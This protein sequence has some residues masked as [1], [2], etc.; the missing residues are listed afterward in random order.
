M[1]L[2]KNV[3]PRDYT[4]EADDK[5]VILETIVKEK[6]LGALIDNNLTFEPHIDSQTKKASKLLAMLQ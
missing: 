4:M 1:H 5:S 2:G 3:S 6:D